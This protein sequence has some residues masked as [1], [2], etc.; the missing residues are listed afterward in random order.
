MEPSLVFEKEMLAVAQRSR[1]EFIIRYVEWIRSVP[2]EVWSVKQ[3]QFIDA[4]YESARESPETLES[5][6]NRMQARADSLNQ[7]AVWF[8]SESKKRTK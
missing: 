3:A 6:L 2:N 5:Y 4:M 1:Q 8:H 7:K